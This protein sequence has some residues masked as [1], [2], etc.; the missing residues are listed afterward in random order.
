MP[1]APT[2]AL[3]AAVLAAAVSACS[4][5]RL[6]NE[7]VPTDTYR[8]ER[9]IAYGAHPRQ[10]LDVYA[11]VGAAPRAPVVVFFDSLDHRTVVGAL[12]APLRRLAPVLD[13]VARFV[14]RPVE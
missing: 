12:A 7:L 2:L 8:S 3:A 4:P 9:D 10:R 5:V 1:S 13:D 11:P 14:A 6:V